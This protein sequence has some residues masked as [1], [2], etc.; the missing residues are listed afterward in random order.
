MD[1]AKAKCVSRCVPHS[2]ASVQFQLDG[3]GNLMPTS[4]T[5][6]LSMSAAQCYMSC[7]AD[8]D[9]RKQGGQGGQGGQGV[10]EARVGG[11]TQTLPP[12]PSSASTRSHGA[13][14]AVDKSFI[15]DDPSAKPFAHYSQQPWHKSTRP[16]PEKKS[17]LSAG[18]M[19]PVTAWAR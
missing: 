14:G 19:I 9:P 1:A 16:D 17:F 10:G 18:N 3:G 11:H 4:A 12:S 8:E 5:A 13:H 6:K 15:G 2:D 7:I